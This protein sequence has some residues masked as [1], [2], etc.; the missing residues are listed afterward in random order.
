LTSRATSAGVAAVVA[1]VFV[2][3]IIFGGGGSGTGAKGPTVGAAAPAFAAPLAAS[4]LAGDANI[5]T[6]ACSVSDPR[7]LVS[8]NAYAKGPVLLG[9]LATDQAKCSGLA[10]SITDVASKHRG[11]SAAVI[12]TRGDRKPL[13][14]IAI[15]NPKASVAWDRDGALTAR[16]GV[17]VCPTVVVVRRGGGVAGVLIGDGLANPIELSKKVDSLLGKADQ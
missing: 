2:G 16:Y 4:T 14:R 11:M 7:A 1:A 3:V 13:A 10:R 9:F 8:C 15:A 12:G 6:S 17:A 5:S